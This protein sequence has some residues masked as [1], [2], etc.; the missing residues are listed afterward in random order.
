MFCTENFCNVC[1]R[2]SQTAY[3]KVVGL[4]VGVEVVRHHNTVFQGVTVHTSHHD[5][6]VVQPSRNL[7][8]F[9]ELVHQLGCLSTQAGD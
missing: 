8:G 9:E 4:A 6:L 7:T 1:R 3:Q 2:Y 5:L